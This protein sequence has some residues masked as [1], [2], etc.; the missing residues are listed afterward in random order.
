[1]EQT[2]VSADCER[3]VT[4]RGKRLPEATLSDHLCPISQCFTQALQIRLLLWA[5]EQN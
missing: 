2:R 5:T 3:T 1:M 4:E